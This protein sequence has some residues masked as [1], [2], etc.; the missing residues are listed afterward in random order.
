MRIPA[1]SAEDHKDLLLREYADLRLPDVEAAVTGNPFHRA[2]SPEGLLVL[3]LRGEQLPEPMLH[4]LYT[5]RLVQ[6]L[7]RGW[8]DAEAVAAQGLRQEPHDDHALRDFHTLVLERDTGRLRGYGTLAVSRDPAA[9]RLDDPAH[10]PFIVER[11]YDI[12]LADRLAP[13]TLASAVGEGKRL[14]RDWAMPR[15]QAAASVPWWVYLSWAH[16]CLQMLEQPG[17]AIVGDGK[18][19][20]AIHQLGLLGFRTRILEDTVPVP[21]GSSD[22]FAPMWSQRERSYPFILTD[23]GRLRPTLGFLTSV[24]TSKEPGSVRARLSAY[25][26]ASA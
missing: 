14:V 24:L 10:R 17:G 7:Q 12:R 3:T 11:D 5:F 2:V 23:G 19:T 18:K 25:L 22:L 4:L 13:D 20:G 26:E 1:P 9:T 15:S 8:V 6:Y 21:P 16:A